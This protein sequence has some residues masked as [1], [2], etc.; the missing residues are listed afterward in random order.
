MDDIH[1]S[2]TEYNANRKHKLLIVF[3]DIIAD[4]GNNIT[5]HFSYFHYTNSFCC[6]EKC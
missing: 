6:T 2:I 5:N 3:H 1:E 4:V